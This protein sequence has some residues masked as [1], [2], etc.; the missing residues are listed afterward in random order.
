MLLNPHHSDPQAGVRLLWTFVRRFWW[1][2]GLLLL[3]IGLSVGS[4]LLLPLINRAVI[5]KA[6]VGK[7][8]SLLKLYVVYYL[9]IILFISL[10]NLIREYFYGLF[11]NRLFHET[12]LLLFTKFLRCRLS[13]L[14]DFSEGDLLTTI[15]DD[16]KVIRN[17]ITEILLACF[18]EI[19]TLLIT[20]FILYQLCP[21]IAWLSLIF[22][23][24]YVVS[25]HQLNRVIKERGERL[26]DSQGRFTGGL[27]EAIRGL[28][29]IKVHGAYAQEEG[30]LARLSR[31]L[32]RQRLGLLLVH[33][34]L[35]QATHLLL[36]G[37]GVLIWFLG[38]Q[39][40]IQG[41]LSLGTLVAVSEYFLRLMRPLTNLANANVLYRADLASLRKVAT[42][43]HYPEEPLVHSAFP[44]EA[45]LL[46]GAGPP[47]AEPKPRLGII[48]SIT[49]DRVA[50]TPP[51]SPEPLLRD[52]SF[53]LSRGDKAALIGRS[54]AGKTTLAHLLLGL[55]TPTGGRILLN[56]R[57]LGD[58]DLASLRER[59]AYT[60][61][62][63]V[64]FSRPLAANLAYPAP[65]P[66]A[67]LLRLVSTL[68]L[69]ELV[70]ARAGLFGAP[71]HSHSLSGGEAQRLALGR[72]LLRPADVF[73][74]DESFSQLDK[75]I[76]GALL[77]DILS[78]PDKTCLVITHDLTLLPRLEKIFLLENGHVRLLPAVRSPSDYLPLLQGAAQ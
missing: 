39:M 15:M 73:I 62:Q 6:I 10:T 54:G 74:F 77:D 57:D 12:R 1:H 25:Y 35:H 45:P 50:F 13:V 41:T 69:E 65:A 44:R 37:G 56:Q 66:E 49:F 22:F 14:D 47:P 53:S 55:L 51:G 76:A 23:V 26:R 60:P 48:R 27:L 8:I 70:R 30:H 17:F 4:S 5:D 11:S 68:S 20:F 32:L 58:W 21:L 29:T 75:A 7:D 28:L 40:T 52:V 34:G 38:G 78:L 43:L 72:T 2:I 46:A 3:F 31:E 63:A 61:Q 19:I 33:A 59:I 18:T 36:L 67:E 16:I 42:L 64:V 9:A 24:V 71:V